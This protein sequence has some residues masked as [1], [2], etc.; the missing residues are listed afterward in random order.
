[1]AACTGAGPGAGPAMATGDSEA[2]R[3]PTV[4]ARVSPAE[5]A[6]EVLTLSPWEVAAL[7]ELRRKSRQSVLRARLYPVLG[8]ASNVLIWGVLPLEALK[9]TTGLRILDRPAALA[10]ALFFS[11]PK[12][13][14]VQ[15]LFRAQYLSPERHTLLQFVA[16]GDRRA[17]L[18]RALRNLGRTVVLYR[19][20]K[21]G[22]RAAQHVAK[23]KAVKLVRRRAAKMY[24][25]G[26][27]YVGSFLPTIDLDGDGEA[28][29]LGE[30]GER[31]A[32][33]LNDAM[34]GAREDLQ[35][36][37][38]QLKDGADELMGAV[39][40]NL[41]SARRALYDRLPPLPDPVPDSRILAGNGNGL[42]DA[43][44]PGPLPQKPREAFRAM[45]ARHAGLVEFEE[46][47]AYSRALSRRCGE[48]EL[49]GAELRE[50]F[51]S[52]D[53]NGDERISLGEYVQGQGTGQ[54]LTRAALKTHPLGAGRSEE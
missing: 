6:A 43:L 54:S 1:M 32:T 9:Q 46:F 30:L 37:A 41:D 22:V 19:L 14:K 38:G 8:V 17:A 12:V 24:D 26:L 34:A 33:T 25:K 29:T 10:A 13:W 16:M 31:L 36:L 47:S 15:L 11:F 40:D 35:G 20:A 48:P 52:F 7:R 18:F 27:G 28:D 4:G 49:S 44:L 2:A 23:T 45:D 3:H 5:G 21:R 53:R 39:G 50:L 42:R 51:E